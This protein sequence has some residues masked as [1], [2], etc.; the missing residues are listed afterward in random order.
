MHSNSGYTNT[1]ADYFKCK[2][3]QKRIRTYMCCTHI[4]YIR[5]KCYI[6]F[7]CLSSI[8]CLV[9]Q[10]KSCIQANEILYTILN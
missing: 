8:I 6:S 7:Y 4:Y 3:K 9:G 10:R 1:I 2:H 5:N